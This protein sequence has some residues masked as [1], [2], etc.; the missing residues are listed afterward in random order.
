MDL[1]RKFLGLQ[2]RQRPS[3]QYL[4]ILLFRC[5]D[6]GVVADSGLTLLGCGHLFAVDGLVGRPG[7]G[8]VG[9]STSASPTKLPELQL[10]QQLLLLLFQYGLS[11]SS[12]TID[13]LRSCSGIK[14]VT[15]TCVLFISDKNEHDCRTNS[16]VG[17]VNESRTWYG[18][19]V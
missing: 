7:V 12:A 18:T 3:F 16:N 5:L 8:L 6:R 10:L 11:L 15:S 2:L 13:N 1:I 19:I 14:H 4:F 17:F 9:P